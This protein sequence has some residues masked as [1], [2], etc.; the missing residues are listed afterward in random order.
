MKRH[1][2]RIHIAALFGAA[3][4]VSFASFADQ[5][6]IAC[7]CAWPGT[8]REELQRVDAV[9]SG[10]VSSVSK[11]QG[12]I[13]FKVEKIWKGPLAKRI[14]VRYEQSDCTYLF[15]VGKKYL[16]YA[17]GKEIFET[18]KCGRTKE[19]DKA[20]DDLKELGEGKEP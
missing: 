1:S 13:E 17:Y 11:E 10:E 14:S 20:S 2:G 18:S 6:A 19:F 9:F 15:V 8:P 12:K 3:L 16:V 4:F 5:R 7:D